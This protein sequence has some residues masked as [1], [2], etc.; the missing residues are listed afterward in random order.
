LKLIPKN[1]E[2]EVET[3]EKEIES[4]YEYNADMYR[5]PKEVKARHILF[6]VGQ[7][8]TEEA[9][10]KIKSRAEKVLGKGA[11]RGRFRR[12]C[13]KVLR[14]TFKISRRG[15]GLFQSRADGSAF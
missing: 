3:T 6:K 4:Y 15:S 13:K 8:D 10:A 1:F 9:K 14:R 2:K 12:P 11:Q 7:D 5:H